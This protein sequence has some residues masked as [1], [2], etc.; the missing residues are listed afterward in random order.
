MRT[1]LYLIVC[2]LCCSQWVT[3]QTV[4]LT[5]KVLDSENSSTLP[6]VNVL[7]KNTAQGTTTDF[8]GEFTLQVNKADVLVFSFI[9]Y[10]NT[11]VT[12]SN[13]SSIEVELE[14]DIETLQ[15]VVVVG[16]GTQKKK[17]VTG[18][19]S[20]ISSEDLETLPI[21]N[22]GQALQ[23]RTSGL[24]IASNSGQPGSGA[25]IRVRGI[26]TLNNN[27]PL[28]VV[29][30]VVVDNG[31]I[32]YLN[33]S[34]IESIEVLKDAA[35]QAIYGARAAAGVIL[36]TTKKGKKG[37]ISVNY[38]A[39]Y[40]TSS[41]ARRLN[42]LNA[43]EYATLRNE[44]SIAAG[45]GVVFEDPASLG[46]GTDWQETIFNNDAR[47]QNHEL[48]V[49]GG[50][51]VS[52]FYLSFGYLGQDGIVATEISQYDRYNVRLNSTHKINDWI[53]VG[54]NLGYSYEKSTGLGNTNS[55]FGGPLSSAI[56]LDPTTPIYETDPA[57]LSSSPFNQDSLGA[58]RAPNGAYYAISG[59]VGQEMSNPLAYIQTRLGNYGWSDNIVGNAFVEM[60]PLKGLVFRSTI[61]TKLAFW[62]GESFTPRYY[63]NASTNTSQTSFNRSTNRRRD[64]NLENTLAYTREFGNHNLNVLVGQGA[65]RDNFAYGVS[66]TVF[67]IPVD[68][69]DD[70]S[71]NYDVPVAST[72]P[73]GYENA[74]HT[75]SSIFSRI[76]YNYDEKYLMTAVI[77]RDGSSRF[78]TNN[79][80][81]FFPSAS[82]G[83]VTSS[84]NFWVDNGIVDFLK[85]RGS[86]GVV[87]N[88]NIGDFAYISTISGGRNYQIGT[89]P[90]GYTIGYSPDAPANPDLKWEETT[91]M[92]VG[93]EATVFTD[94][95]LT[96]DIY[97]K[98]TEG[99]LQ[100]PRIP[101][102]VGAISNPAS[103][104]GT[105]ENSGIELELGYRK[106]IG[107][108][109]LSV[110]GN[111]SYLQNKVTYLGEGVEFLDGGQSFQASSAPIT[112]TAVGQA[113]NSFYG[114]E[115]LGVF[116]TPEEVAAYVNSEGA[117]IQPNAQAGDFKWADN[118]NDGEITEA[119]RDFLGSPVPDWSFGL[120]IRT[121]YKNFDLTI[122]GQGVAGNQIFQGLRRLDIPN[123]NYQSR[124]LGRWT[125]EGTSND[126][127]R[128]N[129][130]DPNGNF[131]RPSEF[132]LE[133]GDYFRIKNIQLGYTLPQST[134]LK[135]GMQQ[136]RVYVMAENLFT[137]TNYT[138][139]DPEIGGGVF[140][141]DRGIYPQARSLMMGLNVTF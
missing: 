44:S 125:G 71:L 119:D 41:P 112:R 64:Y 59:Q 34:D 124:A 96:F 63:L 111:V 134:S 56:N 36:V 32:G 105:M 6:G 60:E 77:R 141:I 135:A 62:G 109:N 12:V 23:G 82:L 80:Y 27:D 93:F 3:A 91:Q 9:G 33:Q 121:E 88:D 48:S 35:S 21:N 47:R 87:G 57:R 18:A 24:T 114:Y 39:F 132:Y 92:N 72:N 66:L 22:V 122:F 51:D 20:S 37:R 101:G 19:I 98:I 52:T 58:V 74:P 40:G 1:K 13:Q 108:L 43:T 113:V 42:L 83:W 76:N 103:N 15:E 45:D 81:G 140:S 10:K 50:N 28:W 133:A 29:D 139:Y 61:G 85:V 129:D 106:S 17:V 118:N 100:N 67:D 69:F 55:E 65:Y 115:I 104:V 94:F 128:L 16:Y 90:D 54:Q 25:T 107:D 123:A 38:N 73:G 68:N 5:G 137:F 78:G 11:E 120:T 84:E 4:T 2:L 26:T 136:A 89:T 49:S 86:Y 79:K 99:I 97:K 70:A 117:L 126:Y 14:Y 8:N 102:Y 116:Q 138:G 127:P 31:G 46:E 131:S 7:V 30:G 130:D 95:D 75:V 110:N 53:T